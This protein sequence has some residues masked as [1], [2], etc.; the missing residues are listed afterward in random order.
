MRF[1][2]RTT[3][4]A[5]LIGSLS[6]FAACGAPPEPTPTVTE[7]TAPEEAPSEQ[8]SSP[9][10]EANG[11]RTFVVDTE[12]SSATY[13]VDEEFLPDMLSKYGIEAGRQNTIGT[14]P[15]VTGRLELN[16]DD[17]SSPLGVNEFQVDL[18]QLESDQNLRDQWLQN[19]GPQF[20][21][22]PTATFVATGVQN[23]PES[24]TEGEL[25]EFQLNG[26]LTVREITQ[27]ATF[28]VEATLDGDRLTGTATANLRMTDFDIEPPDFANTLVV[29]DE[30]QIRIDFEATEE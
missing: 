30:F 26:D 12:Q 21:Q 8:E 4:L 17:L 15:E 25:A 3:M 19:R 20:S 9:D 6:L 2:L 27:P 11:L 13:I 22:F 7:E 29:Q 28:D 5:I 10:T 18:T 23:A 16:L 1:N 14:S 24:Y